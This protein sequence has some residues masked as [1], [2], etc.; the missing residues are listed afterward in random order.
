MTL[1]KKE[2]VK[3]VVNK[4]RVKRPQKTRQQFLF[5]EMDFVQMSSKRSKEIVD[6]LF[7]VIK[8]NLAGGEDVLITGFGKFQVK[9]KWARS[10][11]NPQT[12]EK[13]ILR[14]RRIVTFKPSKKLRKAINA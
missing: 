12:G 14:S 4:V 7:E 5:P 3:G 11:R 2:I 9:F 10:G 6:S 8:E 13:I 1:T